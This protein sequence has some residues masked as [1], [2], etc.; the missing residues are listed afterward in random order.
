MLYLINYGYSSGTAAMNRLYGYLKTFSKEGIDTTLISLFP[1]GSDIIPNERMPHVSYRFLWKEF[2]YSKNKVIN[3]FLQK[4]YPLLFR[5][6][7]KPGDVVFTY[8]CCEFQHYILRV[9]GVKYYHEMTEHPL[10]MRGNPITRFP[11]RKYYK[12]CKRIDGVF[13]ISSCLRDF[14]LSH[15]V[16]KEKVHII[17]MTVDATRFDKVVKQK[18]ERY[19]AYSGV[20]YNSKD[21]VDQLIKSFAII[22]AKYPDVKLY[23]MGPIPKLLDNNVIIQLINDLGVKDRVILKGKVPVEQMPQLLKNA[24]ICALDRPDGLRAKAGF[25]TK[26]GEYLLS[27]NPVVIT[28]VGDIPLFLHDGVSALIASPDDVASFADKL[29]WALSHTREARIIGER[30]ESIARKEFD[31]EIETNKIITIVFNR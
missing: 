21:G 25:P 28:K 12:D 26:L 31:S 13:V 14:F 5:R 29:D 20:I 4:I 3:F 8:G 19:I 7:L 6:C 17:N 9:K 30:G 11:L 2:F 10:I 24:E 23:I 18:G 27:G 15:G 1:S 16:R 22:S